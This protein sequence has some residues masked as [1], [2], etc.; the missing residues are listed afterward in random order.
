MIDPK[1]YFTVE[2][3]RNYYFEHLIGKK[4]GGIDNLSPNKFWRIYSDKLGSIATKCLNGSYHFS[5]YRER[6]ELKGAGKAPRILLIP[7]MRD[8]L[9]LG[10][11]N[12]YLQTIYQEKGYQQTIPN[13][14]IKKVADYLKTQS[15]NK[16]IKFLKTDF[17]DYYGSINREILLKKL[18]HDVEDSMLTLIKHA[19]E[20]PT[21]PYGT[22]S[23]E[24]KAKNY[25]IPQGLS[26]SNILA[27]IYLKDLD[28]HEAKSWADLYIRYVDDILFLNPKNQYTLKQIKGYISSNKLNLTFTKSKLKAGKI[29]KDTLDFIGYVILKDR[30]ISVRK[31]NITNFITRLAGLAKRCE[32]GV[33]DINHRPNFCKTDA[34]FIKYY[35]SEFNLKIDGFKIAEHNYGWMVYYQGMNDVRVLYAMDRVIKKRILKKLPDSIKNKVHS[36]VRVYYDIH[37]TGGKNCLLDFDSITTIEDV[38]NY[39][40]DKGYDLS[41]RT[42]DEVRTIFSQYKDFLIRQTELSI[43]RIS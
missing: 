23:A 33:R 4:G 15:A 26:I 1:R 24:A 39:L 40:T 43:G 16:P 27:Y 12:Q 5:C 13:L 11:L 7:T 3:F 38:R 9:V 29:E 25:G 6:L 42:E 17:H 41:N 37:D 30:R 18:K 36:L 34:K 20:T 35:L 28:E 2:K 8:R 21:I 32:E 19:I 22:K 14:E 31:K 10:V